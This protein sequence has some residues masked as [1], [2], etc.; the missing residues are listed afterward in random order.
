MFD[1]LYTI[2]IGP[3]EYLFDVITYRTYQVFNEPVFTLLVLSLCVNAL[4]LPLYNAAQ[5]VEMEEKARQDRMATALK[6]IRDA[7]RGDERV[8]MTAAY[9]KEQNY[10]PWQALRGTISL[11][12]QIPFFVAAYHYI[13]ELRIIRQVGF[14][15]IRELAY[16]DALIHVG[17]KSINVLPFAMTILNLLSAA[18]YEQKSSKKEKIRTMLIALVF[19]VLLYGSPSALV[20]YWIFNNLFSLGK[21]LY[22][23]Y[24]QNKRLFISAILVIVPC[25]YIWHEAVVLGKKH[26]M[27]EYH[28][29][30]WIALLP[31]IL[32]LAKIVRK[33][34]DSN[35]NKESA[36][37]W[38][39]GRLAETSLMNLALLL[40]FVIPIA[41]VAADPLSFVNSYSEK[42][43]ISLC[44]NA[45]WIYLGLFL[46]W[47]FI[48]YHLTSIES[49]HKF[50]QMAVSI[51]LLAVI[52]Y[53]LFGNHVGMI[54]MQ[55]QYENEPVF[56]KGEILGSIMICLVV[57]GMVSVLHRYQ[58][59]ILQLL[60]MA[61]MIAMIMFTIGNI[62]KTDQE[63]AECREETNGE[64]IET[65]IGNG[66]NLLSFSRNGKN[67]L[68]IMLDRA[69]SCY[70]PY[71]LAEKPELRE[72]FDGF[73]YYPDTASL[74]CYTV[75]GAPPIFGGYEYTPEKMEERADELLADKYIEAA[76]V[77]PILFGNAGYSV[78]VYDIPFVDMGIYNGMENISAGNLSGR[79]GIG[80]AE[81]EQVYERI[82]RDFAFYSL[83]RTVPLFLSAQV[84]DKGNYQSIASAKGDLEPSFMEDY[85]VL[86]HLAE[87]SEITDS[88]KG[89]FT[90]M[91]NNT[92]H[93]L[94][95]LQLPE[96]EPAVKV[97]NS[98]F[99][100][101][102]RSMENGKEL[103]FTDVKQEQHYKIDMAAM[104]RL[105]E[106][107]R[108]LQEQGVYDN[109]RIIIVSDHGTELR[110]IPEYSILNGTVDVAS[111]NALLLYKDFDSKGITVSNERM[112]NADVPALAV[113]GVLQDPKN[114]YTGK[115]IDILQD[116]GE[117]HITWSANRN[118][119]EGRNRYFVDSSDAPWYAVDGSIF[120]EE[121]WKLWRMEGE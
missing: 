102:L 56:S 47:G 89:T 12:L 13:S 85:L 11:L 4:T 40:G 118:G 82:E 50:V 92:T 115:T 64:T 37:R 18:I 101:S 74:G 19:L 14:L 49:R 96:Y 5:K 57:L 75:F 9:Y 23:K 51:S 35:K 113:K 79:F 34:L 41:T 76:T 27:T 54:S 59:A 46:F 3:I 44:L 110:Q 65:H 88:N 38:E 78:R 62:R 26:W 90:M 60:L 7:F 83:Y 108:Y 95:D 22:Q 71:I 20:L 17:G 53:L 112:T 80:G 2:I 48:F 39:N 61:F 93:E 66:Q 8:M 73:C 58:K 36:N 10:R 15:G 6:M 109:T 29:Y 100:M 52:H 25:A 87:I 81:A 70:W 84:Y 114:P 45:G 28:G 33:S 55:L 106:F 32:Y 105:G 67:V 68:I 31:M 1:I 91:V 107:F 103:R 63:F 94:T 42:S 21:N 121:S 43:P 99:D 97:D 104:L 120:A 16:P 77:L 119:D 72:N 98:G 69:I 30:F 117:L 86:K 24:V 116:K 111:I